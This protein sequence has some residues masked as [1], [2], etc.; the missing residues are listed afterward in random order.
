MADK[1][2]EKKEMIKE[3][4]P[5]I[6]VVMG[7][8]DHGKTTIL[9]WFRKTKVAEKESG[10]ITQH[11]GA[12]VVEHTTQKGE[13]KHITFI[14]TPGHEAFSK[15]RSRGAR[16][17]DIAV[18]VIAA[19]EGI[20]PQ[21]KEV[22]DLVRGSEI[23]FVIAINKIDR[24]E[25]N[26]ERVKQE[27]A[28]EEILVESY[29]GKIPS[30]E[31]SAKTGKNM[32]GLL[33]MILLLADL[34]H[35]KA[36]FTKQGTGVVI[37]AHRDPK[38][39]N[40]A[41][42]LIQ[43][44]ALHSGDSIVVGGVRE[45]VKIFENFAGKSI[46]EAGP[47][48]PVLVSSLKEMPGIGEPFESFSD[49]NAAESHAEG[50]RERRI[51]TK[52]NGGAVPEESGKPVFNAIL[53]ADVAG[54][55][56]ALEELVKRFEFDA[57]GINILRSETGDINESDVKLAQATGRVTIVGFRVGIDQST[58]TLAEAS[59]VRIVSGDV[60][61]QL[62]DDLKK[63]VEVFIPPVVTRTDIGKA[64]IVKV[65]KKDGARTIAG[66]RV[67]EGEIKKGALCEIVRTKDV[68]G[69]GLIIQVQQNKIDAP[70]VSVGK[71]F[72]AL[73]E[74]RGTIE[75]GD[76]LAIFEEQITKQTL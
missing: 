65:F 11:I 47:S 39:G 37:E 26:P 52:K 44:G 59:N 18:V 60:I 51:D 10:G 76:V 30:V 63:E 13:K 41:T 29:G 6:V 75:E 5:P 12:Y 64:K 40:T 34:E 73:V 7:H 58:R 71:E 72:G 35:L 17:A 70:S 4:R 33:E 45:S 48:E 8:I 66:G 54:S 38:R 43:D 20:K 3:A 69:R 19:E 24:P 27:L 22:L 1:K 74:F 62:I 31:V 9:D 67:A 25:A 68:I 42:L 21:T 16:V 53:K 36:D 28:K 15:L 61:Y 57:I 56:E 46:Q 32:D 2:F 55:L 23:P 50:I 14:D 49:R